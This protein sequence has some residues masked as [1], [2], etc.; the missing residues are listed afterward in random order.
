MGVMVEDDIPEFLVDIGKEVTSLGL[1]YE[2]YRKEYPEN[3]E[4]LAAKYL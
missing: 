2:E 1:T 4:K 3:L